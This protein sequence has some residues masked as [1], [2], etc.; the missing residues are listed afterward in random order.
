MG[1]LPAEERPVIGGIVNKVRDEI[2]ECIKEKE[3]Q[4][5]K[6]ALNKKLESEKID[7]T[8]PSTRVKRGS[9]HPINRVIEELEDGNVKVSL[10]MQNKGA[11]ISF[12]LGCGTDIELLSPDWLIEEVRN[13]L[14]EMIKRY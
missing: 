2:E 6:E 5:Q 8:L 11:I 12:V 7:I 4:L 1:A 10:D 13:K 9:K 3:E 14:F